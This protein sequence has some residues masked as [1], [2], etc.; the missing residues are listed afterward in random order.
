MATERLALGFVLLKFGF[1]FQM[2]SVFLVIFIL[3]TFFCSDQFSSSTAIGGHAKGLRY[4]TK[5]RVAG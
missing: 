5:L 3:K 2:P 4:L 1:D